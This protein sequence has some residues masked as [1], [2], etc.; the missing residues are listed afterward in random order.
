MYVTRLKSGKIL[1]KY[2]S[3]HS[4]HT[5]GKEEDAFLPLCSSAKEEIAMKL[6]L[7]IPIERIMHGIYECNGIL[8]F[9]FYFVDIREDIGHRSKR[10]EFD[11]L[12]T[13]RHLVKRRDILNIKCRVQDQS[14]IR[15]KDDATSVQLAVTTLQQEEYNPVL[16]YKPQHSEDQEFPQLSKDSF[17]L[18]IQTEFQKQLYQQFSHKIMC[19]DS[20]H[21]TNAYK[22]KLVTL[23][24]PDDFAAGT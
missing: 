9:W 1:V 21:G 12:S 20:T 10:K 8:Q 16:Y 14:V 11:E 5:P 19:I 7:G 17:V 4:N 18:I 15:H 22:F 3:A 24:V 2:V 6:S 23:M 13:R